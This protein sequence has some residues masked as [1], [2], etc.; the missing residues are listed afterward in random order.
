MSEP[1]LSEP[2]LTDPGIAGS[3]AAPEILIYSSASCPYCVAAKNFL[4]SKGR[5]DSCLI[6]EGRDHTNLYQSNDKYPNG[7]AKRIDGEMKRSWQQ[8][9]ALEEAEPKVK[10]PR[11]KRPVK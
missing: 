4:K 9:V 7:L 3:T 1:V 8:A 2:V 11:V 5:E 6:V 10:K